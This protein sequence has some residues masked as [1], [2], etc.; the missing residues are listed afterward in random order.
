M[1]D[2]I[3]TKNSKE[4]GT[5]YNKNFESTLDGFYLQFKDTFFFSFLIQFILVAL[6]YNNV[7]NGHYWKILF[8][9]SLTGLMAALIEN[10]SVAYICVESRSDNNGIVVPFLINEI[11][12]IVT[13]YSIPYLNLIKMKA[14]SNGKYATIIKY[15]IYG[16][17]VPFSVMRFLIGFTRMRKGYLNDRSIEIYHG[18]AFGV[19]GISDILCTA[20]IL[21]FINNYN[22]RVTLNPSLFMQYVQ[23]SSYTILIAVDIV[24]V[25]LSLLY[26]FVNII[27][28]NGVI[29]TKN[30]VLPFHS[31][32]S[33]FLLILSVDACLFKYGTNTNT[34]NNNISS[35]HSEVIS[36]KNYNNLGSNEA[37]SAKNSNVKSSKI[38]YA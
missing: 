27:N 23:H 7:G 21:Y 16:L 3:L 10:I 33:V 36:S 5:C 20:S 37:L 11:F 35:V 34:C 15:T 18:V 29:L 31:F 30:S 28:G 17:F 24:S 4:T 6:M 25:L 32:K 14:I 8:Y 22:R 2:N 38:C 13:E 12:W 19:M 9:S 1:S 26:I